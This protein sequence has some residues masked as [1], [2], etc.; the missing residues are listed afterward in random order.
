MKRD[1]IF[2]QDIA[3][4]PDQSYPELPI[5]ELTVEQ[6]ERLSDIYVN[7]PSGMNCWFVVNFYWDLWRLGLIQRCE[8][9]PDRY[10]LISSL[11]LTERGLATL[12]KN[13]Q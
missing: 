5:P 10:T 13:L 4:I 1:L 11:E 12:D 6:L 3:Y 2:F 9:R 7:P 8:L